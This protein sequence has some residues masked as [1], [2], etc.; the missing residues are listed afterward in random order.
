MEKTNYT[1]ANIARKLVS[2]MTEC[3]FV[4]KN[5]LNS[6]HN[7][8]YATAEDVLSAVNKS[9][10]KYGI[11]CIVIPTLESNI[12]VLNQKG[13]VEHL[14]TVSVHIQLIDSESGE[15]V[16][17]FG[18]GSGQDASDKAVMKAQ[19]AAIK[20]AF[21]LSLCIA[22]G[23]DPEADIGTDERN[24][25]E[26]QYRQPKAPSQR[27][28]DRTINPPATEADKDDSSAICVSCG[29]E[30]TPKVLQYSLA[31]YKRPLCMECQKK[32]HHVA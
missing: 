4:P 29:R 25:A 7:Y 14:A 10:A 19:T 21:M 15:S 11:A 20:Y 22:T 1:N 18:M 2:V 23:D 31:R 12:D 27:Q 17:L 8:R 6:Y 28:M 3:S 16:D 30:I 9:L 5:G 32:E 26:P 13:N 24:Y